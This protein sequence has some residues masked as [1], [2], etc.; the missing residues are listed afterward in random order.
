MSNGIYIGQLDRRISIYQL[1]R[2]KTDTG[3]TDTVEVLFGDFWCKPIDISGSEDSDGKVIALNV[4]QYA[5]RYDAA[6][7]QSG[8]KMFVRDVDGDYNIH[9]IAQVGRK[10]YLILK[11][12]KRE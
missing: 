9:S 12:S 1:T 8:V 7:E 4:R 11:A 10:Q 5:V 3:A 2:V 6:L